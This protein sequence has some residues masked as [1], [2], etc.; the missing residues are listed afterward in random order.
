MLK[1]LLIG[2]LCL[3]AGVGR[4][5]GF[6]TEEEMGS[7]LRSGMTTEDVI[8]VF[9]PP[10][11]GV[12]QQLGPS[13]LRY[14]SP[15]GSLTVEKEGYIGFEVQLVDGKVS[16][17]RTLSGNP[18]YEPM[19]APASFRWSARIWVIIIACAFFYGLNRAFKRGIS[20]EHALL[21]A[22]KER[23]IP[24][25]RLPAELRFV[26]NDTTLQEVINRAGPYSHLRKLPVDQT[27]ASGYGLAE[28]PLGMPAIVLI[29][30]SLPYHAVVILFPEYPF[31]PENRIRAAFYRPPRSDEEA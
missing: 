9:G 29:E 10:S 1:T 6:P 22:Y 12:G 3:I 21:K 7:H 30:Y 15:I 17:W 13:R 4:I 25:Q 2:C 11:T 19:K 5:E 24:S 14:L 20:E 26:T 23:E 16:G 18:S 28:G 27:L 31:K 8:S